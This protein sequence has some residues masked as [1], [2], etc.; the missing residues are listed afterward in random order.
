MY[1]IVEQ[2]PTSPENFE[3]PFEGKLSPDNRWV[4][5]ANLIPWS[6]FEEEYA[7]NF[8]EEMGAPA[9]S[10]RIALGALIIKEK[11][12]ISDR[13]TVEQIK[14]N[15]YLQY[16]IGLSSYQNEAPF[17][18]SILV[19]FRER[20]GVNL[21]NQVNKRMVIN[22]GET[23]SLSDG[24]KKPE[25]EEKGE[26]ESEPKNQGQLIL[27]ATCAPAD[28]RYP[29]DLGILNQAREQ[30][31]E[32]IDSLYE[33]IKDKFPKKPRTY[34][35]EARKAYLEVA[36]RRSPSQKQRRKAIKKQL[37]YIKRNL[38]HLEQ[39]MAEGA[40]L[41]WLSKRQYKMLLVV[42]EVYRQQL[43]MFENRKQSILSRFM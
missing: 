22:P 11:L 19:H 20:I 31:E 24:E 27:D 38:A 25:G 5:M 14:E 6:E 43:W 26:E 9:K 28:I 30:T 12:G 17:E 18:A 29:N 21:V 15:P 16:F 2:P 3:L 32:I 36:K 1:R 13:E 4:I 39:L 34:R 40:S 7:K 10:F 37:K 41:S 42:A 35:E 33:P 8:S 23:T